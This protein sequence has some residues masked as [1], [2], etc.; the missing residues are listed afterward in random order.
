MRPEGCLI[1][2]GEATPLCARPGRTPST[3][4]A[5]RSQLRWR[6]W[7]AHLS[8]V[9]V[10]SLAHL[11]AKLP[12]HSQGVRVLGSGAPSGH[13]LGWGEESQATRACPALESLP[14]SSGCT[15]WRRW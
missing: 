13:S 3:A 15:N 5:A 4:R 7:L 9:A 10:G 11:S 1:H 14:L 2:C 12:A 8:L 6:V